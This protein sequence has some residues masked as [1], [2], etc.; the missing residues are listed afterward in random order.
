[1][2][3][4]FCDKCEK[5]CDLIG[6]V[7]AV[8]VIHNPCPVRPTDMGPI[9]LT[10]DNSRMRMVLCQKCYRALGFPNIYKTART[11]KLDW[12]DIHDEEDDDG[13]TG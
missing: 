5:D 12:R 2:V 8:E 7:I 3:K 6:Y 11:G 1:M 13:Q 4:V 9:K 10:C